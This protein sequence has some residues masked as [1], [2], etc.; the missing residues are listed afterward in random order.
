MLLYTLMRSHFCELY[1]TYSSDYN[2][3]LLH[4]MI[5]R[6]DDVTIKA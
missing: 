6:L 3:L 1:K 5:I 2:H 4:I